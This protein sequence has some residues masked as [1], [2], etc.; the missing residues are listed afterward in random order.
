M[1]DLVTYDADF[2][3]YCRTLTDRQLENVL[4]Q[5]YEAS[6][7]SDARKPDYQAAKMEAEQRGWI[8]RRGER[9]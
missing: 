6:R 9:L 4:R 7:V 8:V 2:L 3:G 5:E 1:A